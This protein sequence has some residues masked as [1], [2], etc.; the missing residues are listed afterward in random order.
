MDEIETSIMIVEDVKKED[1]GTYTCRVENRFNSQE[2]SAFLT[3][4]GIGQF[5]LISITLIDL[6]DKAITMTTIMLLISFPASS[7]AIFRLQGERSDINFRYKTIDAELINK[8]NTF[9]YM[10]QKTTLRAYRQ[11]P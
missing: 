2:A 11:L 4:T 1:E 10:S 8:R 3:V 5:C 7:G 9:R 6:L